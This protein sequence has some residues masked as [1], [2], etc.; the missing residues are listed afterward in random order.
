[1]IFKYTSLSAA[2]LTAMMGISG[3][4]SSNN[5]NSTA[6]VTGPITG[7]GSVYVDGVEYETN[8]ANIT[9]DGVP[10]TEHDLEVGMLV[11]VHG[12]DNGTNGNAFSISFN[13]NLEGVVTQTVAGGGLVVMG[14]SI[15]ANN[16]T[17]FENKSGITP[18]ADTNAD[19]KIDIDDLAVGDVVEISGYPDAN[20]GIQATFIEYNGAYVDGNELEVKGLVANLTATTFTIGSMTVNY[21]SA[22]TSEA[23]TLAD[24]MYVEVK[25]TSVP[26]AITGVFTATKVEQETHEVDGEHGEELEFEGI[27]TEITADSITIGNQTYTLPAGFDLSDYAVGDLVEVEVIVDGNNLIVHEIEDEDHDDDHPGKIEVEALVSATNTVANTITLAGLTISVNPNN[28]IMMDDSSADDHYF[29]LGSISVNDR[30]EIDAIPDGNGGYLAISM[31]RQSGTSSTVELEG[32]VVNGSFSIDGI[33]MDMTTHM[34]D[35]SILA[36]ANEAHVHGTMVNGVLV[37]TSLSVE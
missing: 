15:T 6:N 5:P 21:S 28:T 33:T 14:Y 8:G 16:L 3:C 25:G 4:S 9:I 19:G 24:G 30:I 35:M 11:S 12:S 20:N 13:D 22:D 32:P 36:S 7:F 18:L 27:I 31:E 34:I 10:A 29:N 37:V 23:G 26:D 17:N 2:V 1:M